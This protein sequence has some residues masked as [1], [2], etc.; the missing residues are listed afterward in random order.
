MK[1]YEVIGHT[2]SEPG[3]SSTKRSLELFTQKK[4]AENYINRLQNKKDWYMV[5]EGF[6]IIEKDIV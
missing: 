5:Y 1:I 3:H 6:T 4:N 2:V